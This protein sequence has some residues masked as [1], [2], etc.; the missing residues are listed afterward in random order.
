MNDDR[1]QLLHD[2]VSRLS[3]GRLGL[4]ATLQ[5]LERAVRLGLLSGRDL[6][7]ARNLARRQKEQ[8]PA[9]PIQQAATAL[10]SAC[11]GINENDLAVGCSRKRA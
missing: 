2:L 1:D 5:F 6:Q 8:A 3:T 9:G 4:V 11:L 10:L 7:A